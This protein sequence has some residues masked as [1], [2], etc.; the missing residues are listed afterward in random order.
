M[1]PQLS[2]TV[3]THLWQ[4]TLFAAIVWLAVL[5][6][7]AN[8]A[9]VR[10][11][12]WTAASLKFF[13]PVSWLVGLGAQ[14]DWGTAPAVMQPAASFVIEQVLT[15]PVLATAAQSFA[16]VP[17]PSFDL[18]QSV[19]ALVWLAGTVAVLAWWWRQWRPVRDARRQ[20]QPLAVASSFD[21]RDLIVM[22]SRSAFEPGVVGIWR[23]VLLL[24]DGLADR[25]TH[26]QLRALIAHER[27][28]VRCRDNLAA[29]VHMLVEAVFWFHPVVWW[30]E[31]RMIDERERACDEA[32]LRSGSEPQDYAEGI[33]EVCRSSMESPLACVA[34]V[35]GAN[36]RRRIESIMSG[37]TARPLTIARRFALAGAMALLAAIPIGTG[38]VIAGNQDVTV[39]AD[40]ATPVVFE[41]AAVRRNTS[42]DD[43]T[44]I[45]WPAGGGYTA[46]N[47]AL[48]TLISTAYQLREGQLVNAPDWIQQERFDI[49]ARLERDP[50][51]AALGQPDA[52]R[53]ALRSLLAERFNLKVHREIRPAPM[54]ALVMVTP[55]K[56]GPKLTPS[57]TDCSPQAVTARMA[58]DAAART[59]KP[60][61]GICG[62]VYNNDR[63][64]FGGV[65]S[66][67]AKA[68]PTPASRPV[69]DR[70]GLTG[71]WD[72]D[73]TYTRGAGVAAPGQALPPIDPNAPPPF[74][75]ALQDQLGLKLEP[76]TGRMEVLVIDTVSRPS[77]N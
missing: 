45:R 51:P 38:V 35:S 37:H 65:M 15:P 55:G 73:L 26:A 48:A 44:N 67:F 71:I 2:S 62:S 61:T 72:V 56:P 53:L 21:T 69:V 60:L 39:S 31:R 63:I 14:L 58:P 27:C 16:A 12:L 77:E 76:I 17:A 28:H 40:P 59:G 50:P 9:R 52:R 46:T 6:L 8:H 1:N 30:I 68:L 10:Y 34:G 20:A 22:S 74:F 42:G 75:T 36:L 64:R 13:V 4:S 11:W 47:A 18:P 23:P 43:S 32:V 7:R 19:L 41:V 70:T 5:A 3:V 57:T 66:E 24:P 49:T 54:Y 33:L 29:A 25:L